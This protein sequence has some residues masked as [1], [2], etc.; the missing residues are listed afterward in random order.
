MT[1]RITVCILKKKITLFPLI[2]KLLCT[3]ALQVSGIYLQE[4]QLLLHKTL[5]SLFHLF[6]HL[7]RFWL[8]GRSKAAI[9]H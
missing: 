6:R 5:L 8:C 9:L 2:I 4:Q 1:E 7:C 3:K